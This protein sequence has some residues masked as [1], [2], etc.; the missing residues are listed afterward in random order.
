MPSKL[1]YTLD[2]LPEDDVTPEQSFATGDD[3]AD[4]ELV[5]DI[6]RRLDAGDPY[7]WFTAKVTARLTIEDTVFC[8][9]DYLGGCSYKDE[10]D[11]TQDNYYPDMKKAALD[12]L[13]ANL[14]AAI[15]NGAMAVAAEMY[16]SKL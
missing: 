2:I 9:V 3:K 12:D 6:K 8:G 13:K 15:A 11:F 4:A 7:A 1:E 10:A 5:A 14:R 16:L